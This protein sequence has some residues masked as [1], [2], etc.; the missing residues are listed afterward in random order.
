[1]I[2]IGARKELTP[3][4]VSSMHEFRH[5]IFVRRLRWSL[6]LLDGVERDEYD[7]EDA[8]YFIARDASDDITACARL[9]PTTGPYLL[10]EKFPHLLGS[11]PAPCDPHVWEL[12]RFA[13]NMRKTR[14]GRVLSLSQPTLDLLDAVI[15]YA[16]RRGAQRLALVTS[17][18]IERLLLRAGFEVHRIAAPVQMSDGLF[19]ALYIELPASE[20]PPDAHGQ[21]YPQSHAETH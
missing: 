5:E 19:V 9:L 20:A 16:R 8:V 14:E 15:S 7:I 6:P 4:V 21:Q 18:P 3:E 12:S 1:M 11:N 13:T 17:I 10:L 2:T